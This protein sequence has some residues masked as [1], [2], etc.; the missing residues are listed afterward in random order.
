MKVAVV[1]CGNVSANHFEALELTD[2][3][4]ITAVADIDGEKARKWAEKTGSRAY[5]D[6]DEMLAN[7]EL[8]AVHIATPHYLHTPMAVKALK[9]GINVFLEKPC[10]V[11]AEEADELIKAQTESGKQV[12]ICFQNRYNT[13]SIIVKEVIDSGFYGKI[14]DV[15][16]F[17]TWNRGKDY[18]SDGWHGRADKECG[19]VLINQAIHTIDLVQYFAGGCR[20]LSAH[21]FNDH[22][23]GVIDVE[24]T[25]VIRMLTGSG[26]LAVV[27]ATTAYG[28]NAPVMIEVKLEKTTLRIEGDMLYRLDGDYGFDVICTNSSESTVGKSYWGTGHKAIIRDFYDCLKTGRKFAIDAYEGAKAAKIVAACYDYDKKEIMK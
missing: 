14:T 22:L 18:Y 23:K 15:R 7:E 5:T 6:Y 19:G 25:G 10:S 24:D 26:A 9:K 28:E 2:G 21:V 8:D 16:A 20:S 13:S 1:G 17:V 12:G 11:T 4:E 3:V 27:Y